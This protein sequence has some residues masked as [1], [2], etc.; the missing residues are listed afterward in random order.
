MKA[1]VALIACSAFGLSFAP[2]EPEKPAAPEARQEAFLAGLK[3]GEFAKA[4]DKLLKGSPIEEKQDQVANL[5][6]QTERGVTLYGGSMGFENMGIV[7]QE[8][9][10]GFGIGILCTKQVPVYFYFVWYR[11]TEASPWALVNVWFSDVSK[12][13]WQLRK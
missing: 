8:K 3:A 13:Y 11:P 1:L 9:H 4:Y 10:Q 6:D 5:R 7:R 2:Q 12:D